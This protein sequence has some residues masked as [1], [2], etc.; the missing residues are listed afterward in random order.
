MANNLKLLYNNLFDLSST[1][2]TAS[3]GN[4][5]IDNL[6]SDTK[7]SIWTTNNSSSIL[8]VTF[9]QDFAV[10]TIVMPFTNFSSTTTLT[11]QAQ[12]V[13]S[14]V[15]QTTGP[16]T[17]CPGTQ[18]TEAF[19]EVLTASRVALFKYGYGFYGRYYIPEITCRKLLIT[20]THS[21]NIIEVSR[22]LIGKSWVPKYQVPYGVTSGFNDASEHTRTESG[23]L[24]TNIKPKF[25]ILNF[26]LKYLPDTD[27]TQ[28]RNILLR[29][30]GNPIFVSIF[31]NDTDPNREQNH[32]IY[33]KLPQLS[34]IQYNMLDLY[35][36]QVSL[37]E[38]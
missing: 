7:S 24:I 8:T 19:G 4:T 14:N 18:P 29:G 36:T 15:L 22:L 34:P 26:D 25:R 12:D 30:S 31:P 13:N 21:E 32:M 9:G 27:R 23:D 3:T 33:G 20:I 11:V 10:D 17:A 2:I 37:E 38:I 1:S 16:V 6:K 5:G 28:F 35:S